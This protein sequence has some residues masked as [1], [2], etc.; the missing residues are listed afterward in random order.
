MVRA[1]FH[2]NGELVIFLAPEQHSGP[3]P[4]GCT[5]VLRMR[6]AGHVTSP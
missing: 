1:T 6:S 4:H 2:F 3:F 5:P